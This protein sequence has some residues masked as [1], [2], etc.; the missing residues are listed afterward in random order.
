MPQCPGCG[1]EY[2]GDKR[3]CRKCGRPLPSEQAVLLCVTCGANLIE[4]K[5]F[6]GK[7]GSPATPIVSAHQAGEPSEPIASVEPESPS[8]VSVSS[9]PP[10]V[11]S[12]RTP[13]ATPRKRRSRVLI[14]AAIV[15][16]AVLLIAFFLNSGWLSESKEKAL[17]RLVNESIIGRSSPFLDRNLTSL[18]GLF[19]AIDS[20]GRL[21]TG[22]IAPERASRY[23]APP[24][25]LPLGCILANS[26]ARKV[27]LIRVG[28]ETGEE[29]RV[30]YLSCSYGGPSDYRRID[31]SNVSQGRTVHDIDAEMSYQ[32]ALLFD[33][34]QGAWRF[35]GMLVI[36]QA[37][38]DAVRTGNELLDEIFSQFRPKPTETVAQGFDSMAHAV[39]FPDDYFAASVLVGTP[40][41][42]A[43]YNSIDSLVE[44]LKN[45]EVWHRQGETVRVWDARAFDNDNILVLVPTFEPNDPGFLWLRLVKQE[46][47]WRIGL[48]WQVTAKQ[49]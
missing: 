17:S 10:S 47:D 42:A 24:D 6:C 30:V 14:A 34:L 3:F 33:R 27:Y 40:G 8:N 28:T 1:A 22:P 36:G 46:N 18:V 5:R 29:R 16:A 25:R 19:T 38:G 49:L 44:L 21:D 35:L 4:G 13:T 11:E 48:V 7:C 15:C 26:T 37:N 39:R 41:G 23:E 43:R 45:L 2:S 20:A 12:P 9:S 31:R 32:P